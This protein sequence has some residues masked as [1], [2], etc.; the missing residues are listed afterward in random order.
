MAVKLIFGHCYETVRTGL[1]YHCINFSSINTSIRRVVSRFR[2]SLK[3]PQFGQD[4]WSRV[5][6]V[7]VWHN[8]V[9]YA[10]TGCSLRHSPGD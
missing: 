2:D 6:L 4:S 9:E 7:V 3:C 5:A 10:V 8:L 1:S